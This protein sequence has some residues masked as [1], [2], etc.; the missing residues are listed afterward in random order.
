MASILVSWIGNA[1]LDGVTE[2]VLSGPLSSVLRFKHFEH[3][4]LLHNQPADVVSGYCDRLNKEFATSFAIT[5]AELT[6]PIHFADIYRA[7]DSTLSEISEQ[8]PHSQIYIQLTSG[9]PAMTSVSILTGKTKYQVGF[10]QSS[11]EQGVQQ[12]EIP[13]DIAAD[14]LPSVADTLDGRLSS[15]MAGS[16]PSTAAFASIITK[17][18][19]MLRLKERAAILAAREVPV[20]IHGETGT[21]KELFARA[22]HNSSSR[23][24]KPFVAINCGAIPSELIDSTLFG[25]VKG[26]FTGATSN[27]AGVFAQ[28]DAGTLFLDEFGE[29]P[30]DAQVRLLRVLQDGS[31][32]PVGAVDESFSDV[33]IIVATNK[34]LVE[35]I[36]QGRFREDLFYR[37]AIGV[38][39]LPALRHRKGDKWLLAEYLVAQI[40]QEAAMQPGYRDKKI[41]VGA[42]KVILGHEWPGNIR[43]LHATL[44]RASLWGSSEKIS[45]FDIKEAMLAAPVHDEQILGL[46]LSQGI[47]INEV[48]REVCVHYIERALTESDGSKTKAAEL[49]SLKN[50]QTLNNWMEKYGIKL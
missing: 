43:E 7:L 33:R 45:E 24:A 6:S 10:L 19:Q 5:Q 47:D 16:A 31:Y 37:V 46:D 25:H 23:A 21:G 13:F 35:E 39:N 20:L 15:L 36:A 30:L 26:A 9:T 29:L 27:K 11:L 34:N 12:V 49:L 42:K 32:I 41:S 3:A 48:L 8:H 40:N 2:E 38:I 44:L 1:D 17:D 22:I 14:F 28:A 50:Y 18:P 4:Y